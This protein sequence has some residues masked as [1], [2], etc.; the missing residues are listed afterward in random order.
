M[1]IAHGN[2]GSVKSGTNAVLEV[3]KWDY[4]EEDVAP[5]E[6]TAMGDTE[7]TPIASGCKRGKASM[8]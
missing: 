1:A 2:D 6:A 3:Q 4:A 7:A 8:V 5:A